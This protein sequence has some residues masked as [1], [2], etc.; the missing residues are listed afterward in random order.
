MLM[1]QRAL[2]IMTLLGCWSC[3][4]PR[5]AVSVAGVWNIQLTCTTGS[6]ESVLPREGGGLVRHAAFAPSSER[7][8]S[9]GRLSGREAQIVEFG[10]YDEDVPARQGSG[11]DPA[12][13]AAAV[14]FSVDSVEVTFN[15]LSSSGGITLV[16]VQRPSGI[17]G[18]WQH[19]SHLVGGTFRM[20]RIP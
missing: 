13:L 19:R 4:D 1:R 17:E 3:T 18:T 15:P 14:S 16:G 20:T 11:D 8:N 9:I 2:S 6:C 5:Q 7:L 12:F 10:V